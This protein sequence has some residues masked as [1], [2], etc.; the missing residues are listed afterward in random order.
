MT[1]WVLFDWETIDANG[2][3]GEGGSVVDQDE[4]EEEFQADD[5]L[6]QNTD[7]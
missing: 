5:R 7:V 2:F 3:D 4:E 6:M 1:Q